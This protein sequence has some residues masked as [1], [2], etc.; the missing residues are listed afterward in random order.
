MD[1]IQ[2]SLHPLFT[3]RGFRRHGRTY[4]R[5]TEAGV[6][7]V[8]NFQ[9]GSSDPPGT[10]YILG[11]RE[12]LHGL[13]TLNLGIFVAE[14]AEHHAGGAPRS[15]AHDYNCCLRARLGELSGSDRDIWWKVSPQPAV[16]SEVQRLLEA[17]GFP[18]LDRFGSRDRILQEL[19]SNCGERLFS[20]SSPSRIVAAVILALRGDQ[21]RAHRLLSEQYRRTDQAGHKEYVRSLAARLGLG[22]IAA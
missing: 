15:Y 11:L 22:P 2:A 18:F 17:F 4:N 12:N 6:V 16:I 9:M 19:E 13:F 7:Q 5:P 14:V 10:T 3:A 1:A 21:A 8:V 20:A